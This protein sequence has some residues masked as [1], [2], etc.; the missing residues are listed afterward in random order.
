[1]SFTP[2]SASFSITCGQREGGERAA[3]RGEHLAARLQWKD[4][5]RGGAYVVDEEANRVVTGGD[6]DVS[7]PNNASKSRMHAVF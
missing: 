1:M 4:L 7:D 6:Q 5:H 3:A 2:Y